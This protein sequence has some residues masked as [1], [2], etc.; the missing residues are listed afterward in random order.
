MIPRALNSI[1]Q[2]GRFWDWLRTTL[3][4]T[5][6]IIYRTIDAIESQSMAAPRIQ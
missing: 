3:A 4:G 6:E 5:L 2:N 1:Q